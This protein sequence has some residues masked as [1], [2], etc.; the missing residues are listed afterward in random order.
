[1]SG[2]KFAPHRGPAISDEAKLSTP[3]RMSVVIV[4]CSL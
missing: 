1:L 4:I 3:R 2:A